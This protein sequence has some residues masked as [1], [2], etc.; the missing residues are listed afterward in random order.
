MRK[1][2]KRARAR[3]RFVMASGAEIEIST[4]VILKEGET[5]GEAKG[6]ARKVLVALMQCRR[7]PVQPSEMTAIV[8]MAGLTVDMSRVEAFEVW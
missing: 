6:K 2:P 4:H 5:P 7:T 1:R 3:Y 8:D